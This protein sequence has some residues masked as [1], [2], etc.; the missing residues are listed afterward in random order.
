MNEKSPLISIIVPVYKVEPYLR[1]CVAS[2][3]NQTYRNLEIILVDDGSPDNCGKICDE[4]AQED[5]RIVVIHQKNGGQSSAR[6][7]GL[8]I[9]NGEFVGFVDSD[10]Y[11]DDDMFDSLYQALSRNNA[12][13]AVCNARLVS[14]EG[15]VLK[16]HLKD[17]RVYTYTGNEA[18]DYLIPTLNNA[19]WNKLFYKEALR[20]IRFKEGTFHGEDFLFLLEYYKKVHTIAV[21]EADKYN[22]LQR[23]G[24]VT[25]SVFSERKVDEINSKDEVYHIIAQYFPAYILTAT[26]WCYTARI[27]VVRSIV[28][29]QKKKK[30]SSVYKECVDYLKGNY[31]SIRCVLSM[32]EKV[33]AFII[34]NMNFVYPFLLRIAMKMKK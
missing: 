1:K 25:G 19:V 17:N 27:N 21:L 26:K 18:Y 10:D 29:A 14:E 6:N 33:E 2:I 23:E 7:S 20:G 4:L 9:A 11:I 22:Y 12:E 31:N 3:Q 5:N 32:R 13:L 30:W 34:C 8:V 15:A 16:S 24:S 28:Q